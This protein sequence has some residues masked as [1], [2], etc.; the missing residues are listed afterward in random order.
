MDH[1][2]VTVINDVQWCGFVIKLKR[3]QIALLCWADVNRCLT[4]ADFAWSKLQAEV[5][6]VTGPRLYA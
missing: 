4:M 5:A 6:P 3:R 1:Y 2:R